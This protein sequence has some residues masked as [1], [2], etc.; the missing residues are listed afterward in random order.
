M[1]K[2][3]QLKEHLATTVYE[4]NVD[5]IILFNAPEHWGGTLVRL[6]DSVQLHVKESVEEIKAKIE[7]AKND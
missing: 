3:I 1:T 2:F 6:I 5:H 4:V 7:G